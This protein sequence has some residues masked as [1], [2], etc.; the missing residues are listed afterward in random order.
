MANTSDLHPIALELTEHTVSQLDTL[1]R[2]GHFPDRQAVIAA[3]VDRLY[4]QEPQLTVT[5]QEAFDR[6]CGALHLDTTRQSLR[7]AELDRLD[8]EGEQK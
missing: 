7:D 8:W 2:C 6:L 3:A 5:R 4:H 1:M